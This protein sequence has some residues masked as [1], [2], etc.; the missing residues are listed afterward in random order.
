MAVAA[1]YNFAIDA[2]ADTSKIF[3]YRDS[4]DAPINLTGFTARC[5]LRPT[6]GASVA[7]ELTTA[8]GKLSLG[9]ASGT[10]TLTLSNSDT[11]ALTLPEYL[12]D[13]EVI[14]ADLK[15]T[16]VVKGAITVNP[17]VTR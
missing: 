6:L 12:Y 8:N 7:L 9:G 14:D 16:R 2:G 10:I 11:S 4:A 5:Q 1:E 3:A 17:E 15:V 13:V